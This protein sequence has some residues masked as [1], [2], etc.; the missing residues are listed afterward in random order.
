MPVLYVLVSL[1][2]SRPNSS[3]CR[4][5]PLCGTSS[6]TYG[7]PE[8][9]KKAHM[10]PGYNLG[11]EGFDI[12]TMERK[13]AYVIDTETWDL[14]NGS[15][16]LYPNV[17]MGREKQKVP[18]AVLDWRVL[19]QCSLSVSSTTY[20]SAETLVNGS[21]SSVTNNWKLGLNIPVDPSVT[22]GLGLGGSHSR[23]AKFAMQKSK[24]DRYNFYEHEVHCSYYGYRMSSKPPVSKD[25]LSAVNSL[26]PHSP[27]SAP[28]YR[29]L[30]D[31]YGTHYITQVVLGG[32]IKRLTESEVSDCLSVEASANVQSKASI[33]AMIKHC[34]AKSKKL[35]HHFNFGSSFRER[36]TTTS[37]GVISRG[38]VL[39][40]QSDPSVYNK[41]LESLKT[42]PDV[43][44]YNL[45]P[46][47]TIL[48][49]SLTAKSGIKKE[50]ENYI[51]QNALFKKCSEKCKVGHKSNP[52]DPCACVCNNNQNIRSNCCPAGKGRAT[53]RVYSLYAKN[54][55]G[56]KWSETDGSVEVTY[57]KQVKRT[58]IIDDNDNPR[59]KEWF[60]FGPITI[61][62]VNKLEFKVYDEDSA[63]NSDLLG[64]CSFDLRQGK[65]SDSCTFD[66]GTFFFSYTVECAPS[67][68]GEQCQEYI[69]S[70]S[71][72]R[73]LTA[74]T[75]GMGC[76]GR[77]TW[78]G[79]RSV[80]PG[81]LANVVSE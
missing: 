54:L 5:A 78:M 23:A 39:F 45:R 28:S 81:S 26:P 77:I 56:D 22:V 43:V 25:F 40:G 49:D 15:C 63:W 24:Q 10:V 27:K 30:L 2:A 13:G 46:L 14:G 68:G 66:H 79:D 44:K 51:K 70:P 73:W 34:R 7:S 32:E 9:C 42:S 3:V 60:N 17:Y 48:P 76:S 62:M 64:K 52:R 18:A 61:N 16:K 38:D 75:P 1:G 12:V 33:Q 80:T 41:W 35:G 67:L 4:K 55:Y 21:T 8:E 20:D 29:S 37:G 72:P 57:D 6:V 65:V 74:S 31:T 19:P 11:G 59:W 53:L 71:A 50:I 36:M 58:E 69:P 47:H